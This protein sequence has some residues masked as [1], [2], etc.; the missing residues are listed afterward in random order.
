MGKFLSALASFAFGDV[1]SA[2]RKP[3]NEP[4]NPK[5]DFY[6]STPTPSELSDEFVFITEEH[7]KKYELPAMLLK[8]GQIAVYNYH[9]L[10]E[11]IIEK[12]IKDTRYFSHICEGFITPTLTVTVDP[13]LLT[14]QEVTLLKERISN[15][16]AIFYQVT[17]GDFTLSG[18][19]E[20]MRQMEQWQVGALMRNKF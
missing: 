8:P 5:I 15:L 20:Y 14:F 18:L 17:D 6:P 3:R 1:G 13:K 9:I 16:G 7:I 19:K 12:Q 10:G 2:Y 11:A 4:P